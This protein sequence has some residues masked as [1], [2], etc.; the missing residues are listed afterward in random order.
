[1]ASRIGMK[2]SG[3]WLRTGSADGKRHKTLA[4]SASD[5]RGQRQ[6]R[7]RCSSRG[8]LLYILLCEP[9]AGIF[10]PYRMVPAQEM[11]TGA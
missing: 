4:S 6:L 10:S 2:V 3:K 11:G 8:V 7:T 9:R 1:M 5:R